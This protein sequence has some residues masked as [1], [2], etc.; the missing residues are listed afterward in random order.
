M[1]KKTFNIHFCN[2]DYPPIFRV[3]YTRGCIDTTDSPDVEHEVAR[4][5]Y[6]I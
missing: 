6:R 5:M 3:A 4:N 1:I 2:L